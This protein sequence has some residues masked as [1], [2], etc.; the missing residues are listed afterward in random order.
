MQT[1]GGMWGLWRSTDG[2]STFTQYPVSEMGGCLVGNN[3]RPCPADDVVIDPSTGYI[4]A[5]VDGYGIF[6]STD[7][8]ASFAPI[9]LPGVSNGQV[10]RSSIAASGGTVYVMVGSPD[11]L[12][13]LGLFKS[14]DSGS[15][16]TQEKVPCHP[17]S[18]GTVIDGTATGASSSCSQPPTPGGSQSFYDQALAIQPGS[19]GNNVVFGG[20]GLYWSTDSGNTWTFLSSTPSTAMHA[21]VHALQF[22]PFNANTLYA[23]TDGGLFKIDLSVNPWG[24]APLNNSVVAAQLYNIGPHPI[25]A[26]SPSTR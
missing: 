18:T 21:D 4:F 2:G 15:T 23:G 16:W 10:G 1:T 13:Y 17:F 19:G 9:T 6:R 3:S 11:A 22:D 25:G 24:I 8:G 14:T 5:A 26:N 20:V 12:T 7:S